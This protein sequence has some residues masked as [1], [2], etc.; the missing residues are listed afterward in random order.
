MI[1]KRYV[2]N[3]LI[4]A[5]RTSWPLQMC[6]KDGLSGY[7]YWI[8]IVRFRDSAVQFVKLWAKELNKVMNKKYM[9]K[10]K[11]TTLV[12]EY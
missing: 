9:N 10:I 12:L 1:S 3:I 5:Q 4:H 8:V 7:G 11:E 2:L 6:K